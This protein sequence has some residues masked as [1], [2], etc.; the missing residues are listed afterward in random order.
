MADNMIDICCITGI[1][2]AMNSIDIT[3]IF[4]FLGTTR[5]GAVK[6]PK[7][8]MLRRHSTVHEINFAKTNLERVYKEKRHLKD[9][10]DS[11]RRC[12]NSSHHTQRRFSVVET[13][14]ATIKTFDD[15]LQK[16]DLELR[17]SNAKVARL[18]LM[19]ADTEEKLREA[20]ALGEDLRKAVV[21]SNNIATEERE[22]AEKL[23]EE[24]SALLALVQQLTLSRMG[25]SID[26][27]YNAENNHDR[28]FDE[29]TEW[30]NHEI[31]SPNEFESDTKTPRRKRSDE[32]DWSKSGSRDR[33]G[34]IVGRQAS[35][36]SAISNRDYEDDRQ[37]RHSSFADVSEFD[38]DESLGSEEGNEEEEQTEPQRGE[39]EDDEEYSTDDDST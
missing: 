17:E 27:E 28:S 29:E 18:E 23:E 37:S 11:L 25:G 38:S 35:T 24:K 3:R 5:R 12:L 13:H 1:N 15:L 10:V 33:N 36:E 2:R 16:S 39:H 31:S 21:I 30:N 32:K 20:E 34:N 8:Q 22:K 19:K 7:G 9:E 6:G 26:E 4:N 14:H